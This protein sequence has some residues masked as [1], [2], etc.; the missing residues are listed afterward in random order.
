MREKQGFISIAVVVAIL[1]LWGAGTYF[2]ILKKEAKNTSEV[3][4]NMPEV[5]EEK[6]QAV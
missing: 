4:E 5:V 6:L 2:A 1:A 3:L